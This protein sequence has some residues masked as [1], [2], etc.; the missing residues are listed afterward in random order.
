MNWTEGVLPVD[1]TWHWT[2]MCY[3][4]GKYVVVASYSDVFAYSYD[5]INWNEGVLPAMI[6]WSSVCYGNGKFVAV[7]VANYNFAYST[8]GIN[9]NEGRISDTSRYWNSVC[10]GNGKFVAVSSNIFAYSTDGIN[11]T[12][13]G[14]LKSYGSVCY[15]NDKFVAV[16]DSSIFAICDTINF[17]TRSNISNNNKL[18]ILSD[19]SSYR[20]NIRYRSSIIGNTLYDAGFK[21]KNNPSLGTSY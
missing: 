9:W 7:A 11:W 2:S 13:G 12:E 14:L 18:T 6:A 3:G 20:A 5:G 1:I 4:N 10:Y 16:A 21:D 19:S 15:G 8:D 17:S